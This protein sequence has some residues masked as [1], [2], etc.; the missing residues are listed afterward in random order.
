MDSP[1]EFSL[2][3]N[4]FFSLLA[5]HLGCAFLFSIHLNALHES[6]TIPRCK[7]SNQ[8]KIYLS[9]TKE[10][11]RGRERESKRRDDATTTDLASISARRFLQPPPPPPLPPS[12]A[13]APHLR[14]YRVGSQTLL[15]RLPR[16]GTRHR[17]CAFKDYGQR[18][19]QQCAAA[20]AA[21]APAALLP[22]VC[23]RERG[24]RHAHRPGGCGGNVQRGAF[25]VSCFFSF[26]S[27]LFSR[28]SGK[29][30]FFLHVQTGKEKENEKKK[31]NRSRGGTAGPASRSSPPTRRRS[32]IS[33]STPRR[34]HPRLQINAIGNSLLAR[35]SSASG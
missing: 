12:L 2:R 30:T 16:Y 7:R 13:R 14:F 15:R 25:L 31:H 22:C 4:S 19:A 11:E 6:L 20:A 3:K 33:S 21:A 17:P 5:R 28:F 35:R 27:F 1:G 32:P 23:D 34:H 18:N 9:L 8:R 24:R 29:E 26:F 10:R